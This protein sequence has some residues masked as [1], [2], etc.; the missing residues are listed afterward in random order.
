M[1]RSTRGLLLVGVM[2]L[3]LWLVPSGA[4][5]AFT[6]CPP[7]YL[8]T[9]CGYLITVTDSETTVEGDASQGP[10]E[11]SDDS[12]IGIVN[13]SSKPISSIPLSA[14]GNLFGFENDGICTP[15]AAPIPPKCVV[16][17]DTVESSSGKEEPGAKT[18]KAGTECGYENE[19]KGGKPALT[20]TIEENCG[21]APPA[22]EPNGLRFPEG[23]AFANGFQNND[24]VS[25]YEGPTS[26]FTNISS[27]ATSGV[28]NFSPALAPGQSTYFSLE[29]PPSTGFGT[30]TTVATTLTGGGLS[31]AVISVVQGSPVTDA[32][33]IGGAGASVATGKVTYSVYSDA[34]CTALVSAAGTASVAG[35]VA[36]ASSAI[37]TLAPGKYYW[38]AKYGGDVNNQPAAS[39]C[40]SE[41][42]TVLAPTTTTTSQSGGGFTG[43]KITV[44]TGTPV[45][46][47]ARISGSLAASSTG[48]VSYVLYKDNKCTVAA[49]SASVG[50]VNK[51]VAGASAA[52][53]PAAGTY[54]WKA[55]YSGDAVNAPSTSACGAEVLTVAKPANFGLAS[56]SKQCV[57]KRRFIAH[58]R[59]PKG[60]KLLS[61]QV[62]INGKLKTTGKLV[63]GHTTIN[64][65]GLPKG[66]FKVSMIATSTTG[67]TYEDSR[68]FH[69]CVPKK[70][71]H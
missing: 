56:L 43:A 44:P 51:G 59:A 53:K 52:V 14:E 63:K 48:S 34:A 57:S 18:L 37:S 71:H 10:Y 5:A 69:T 25:G 45:T 4:S 26:W 61:V 29:S 16:L 24:A 47:S 13:N 21:F 31:G 3:V 50:V 65:K 15:G 11:G 30:A 7:V 58:P 38:Q 1:R 2:M 6:Q 12:L 35:G 20:E 62:F 68:T 42:L 55:T 36:G 46:D 8:D 70:H 39:P 41:V 40:G 22:G 9:G 54:Y 27:G 23:V 60:V 67:Q 17:E 49:S 32:A 66:T 33:T 64:L 28:V 19:V